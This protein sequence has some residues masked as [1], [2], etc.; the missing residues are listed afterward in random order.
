MNRKDVE[1]FRKAELKSAMKESGLDRKAF[2]AMFE[3]GGFGGH[4]L[5]DRTHLLSTM[6]DDFVLN[7]P[8]ALLNPELYQQA[9]KASRA[10]GKLYQMVG[11]ATG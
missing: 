6:V 3:L 11:T 9:T 4:E 2:K 10:L 7:H 5:L 8:A 1:K